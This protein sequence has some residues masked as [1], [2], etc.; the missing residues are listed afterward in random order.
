MRLINASRQ[1]AHACE[2]LSFN[3]VT[4]I[5]HPLVYA[6]EAYES[7]LRRYAKSTKKAIFLGI[8]PG[9][10]GMAQTGIPFGDAASV[11]NYLRIQATIIPPP[12]AHPKRPVHG[13]NCPRSEVSGA[14]LWRF[15]HEYFG[16]A[17]DFFRHYLVLNYCPLLF[18]RTTNKSVVN[19]T[20]DKLSR[21]DTAAL[22]RHC[23]DFIRLADEVLKP[24]IWI[25][26]GGFATIRLN[27]LF[28]ESPPRI[29]QILHPSPASPVA[30][31][32]FF[33]TAAEQLR[34]LS[35]E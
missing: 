20:P 11:K 19:T 8:N 34:S 16:C 12:Y 23:D 18:L 31:R 7:Y 22:Y 26:I 4:H 30:N 35:V 28:S 13:I 33:T 5:Y 14:R 27:L 32:S 2:K 10:W 21:T 9:P 29:G 17:N 6:R 24:K 15:F 25:G 1:L 3:G